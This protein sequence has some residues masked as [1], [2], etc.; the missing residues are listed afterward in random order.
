MSAEAYLGHETFGHEENT[1][2]TVFE[3]LP[4]GVMLTDTQGIIHYVNP[5]FESATGYSRQE[6]LGHTPQLLKSGQHPDQFF[7]HLW[8][9]LMNGQTF[10]G[11]MVNRKKNGELYWAQQTITPIR[12]NTGDLTHFVAVLQDV[13]ELRRKQE[14]EVQLR[15]AREVQQRF[16][17]AAPVMPGFDLG[18]AAYPANET[19][20]DYFDFIP[21][22]NDC[23]AIAVGDVEGHGFGSALVM[24]LTR[25]YLR[26]FA[27]MDLGPD[28]ILAQVNQMLVKDLESECFVTLALARLDLR[29]RLLTYCGAGHVPGFVLGPWGDVVCRLES[30]GPPLGLFPE[31]NFACQEPIP[32]E[33]GH[34]A[35]F[36]TDG[37]TE[38]TAPDGT[39]FG[40]QRALEHVWDHHL[41]PASRIADGL[42]CAARAFAFNEP[43]DDDTTSVIVKVNLEAP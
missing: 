33:P 32:L 35:V 28:Q 36:L 15:L 43:Q 41:E 18:A 21:M 25:A 39:E 34:I 40:T 19:G 2:H 4:V 24:A 11:T 29:R 37:I 14:Q 10:Q 12:D 8:T 6:V 23:L 7:S 13:T 1:L 16:Y 20:G 38:S 3:T 27:A 5:A 31:S 22:P 17:G 9:Q 30:S 42:H 26:S